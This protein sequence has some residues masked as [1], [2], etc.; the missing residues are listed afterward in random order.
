MPSISE[1]NPG[2]DDGHAKLAGAH[3]EKEFSAL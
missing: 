2:I 3:D 1:G